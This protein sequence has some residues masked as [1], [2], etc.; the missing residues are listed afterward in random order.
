MALPEPALLEPALLP[1]HLP[2]PNTWRRTMALPEPALLP[3]H[4]PQLC[5][6]ALLCRWAAAPCY[7][8]EGPALEPDCVP[9]EAGIYH[10][11]WDYLLNGVGYLVE[12]ALPYVVFAYH[13]GDL[14]YRLRVYERPYVFASALIQQGYVQLRD[15]GKAAVLIYNVYEGIYAA[16]L[17]EGVA[18]RALVA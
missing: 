16:G 10:V 4:L 7:R 15:N 3:D 13:Q 8:A 18:K 1:D 14:S 5:C 2:Q 17:K 6:R 11:G 12:D 9:F